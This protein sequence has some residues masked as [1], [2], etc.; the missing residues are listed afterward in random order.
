M[1]ISVKDTGVGIEKKYHNA[2]FDRF[3]QAYNEVSE[4]FGGSG[5]G[6]TVTK[7]LVTLHKGKIFVKS[8]VDEGSEFIIILPV[9]QRKIVNID[10]DNVQW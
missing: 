8:E 5:L 6:L 9:K 3:G 4:E 1:K 2:I 7:Q 10:S